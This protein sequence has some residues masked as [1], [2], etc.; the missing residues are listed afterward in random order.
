MCYLRYSSK[1]D[2]QKKVFA[3]VTLTHSLWVSIFQHWEL[4]KV[5]IGSKTYNR[6]KRNLRQRYRTNDEKWER[7]NLS[8]LLW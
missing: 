4:Q 8:M 3:A 7:K 5:K 1:L 2:S 6:G